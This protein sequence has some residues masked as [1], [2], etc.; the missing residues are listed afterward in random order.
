MIGL[1]P[2]R[3]R[4]RSRAFPGP[5]PARTPAHRKG[6]KKTVKKA[7]KESRFTRPSGDRFRYGSAFAATGRGFLRFRGARLRGVRDILEDPPQNILQ[8]GEEVTAV[9]LFHF[10]R[11]QFGLHFHI[12]LPCRR[13]S[14]FPSGRFTPDIYFRNKRLR[15][16]SARP[17]LL[18]ECGGYARRT[19][20]PKEN[21]PK[22]YGYGKTDSERQL[23]DM[24]R[25][26]YEVM[27]LPA[28]PEGLCSVVY[29]QLYDVEG[30]INGLYTR[31]RQALKADADALR[32]LNARCAKALRDSRRRASAGK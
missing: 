3:G 11:F 9:Y 6:R 8:I 2:L 26:L 12:L 14:F 20:S 32:S 7:K 19:D 24:I 16:R 4:G 1:C 25:R 31:D 22:T 15:P 17:L 21:S 27:V 23:T 10:V 28:V 29:T 13:H 30:E 18:S 5:R